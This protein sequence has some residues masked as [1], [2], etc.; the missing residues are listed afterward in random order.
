MSRTLEQF[1]AFNKDAADN[2][3]LLPSNGK[4]YMLVLALGGAKSFASWMADELCFVAT[5]VKGGI[6]PSSRGRSAL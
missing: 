6:A 5:N 1:A 3:A 4:L 2:K